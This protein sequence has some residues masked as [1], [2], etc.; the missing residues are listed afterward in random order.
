VCERRS[1]SRLQV[2]PTSRKIIVLVYLNEG[3]IQKKRGSVQ[4]RKLSIEQ[5]VSIAGAELA[6][7]ISIVWAPFNPPAPRELM[8]LTS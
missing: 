6:N 8:A 5:Q 2:P 1:G 3:A 4:T 7:E